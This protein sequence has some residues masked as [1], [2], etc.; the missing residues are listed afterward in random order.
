MNSSWDIKNVTTILLIIL[1]C[2]GAK[3]QSTTKIAILA[4]TDVTLNCSFKKPEHVPLKKITVEWGMMV[5]KETIKHLVYTF[6]NESAKV[7]REGSRVDQTGLLQGNASLRLFN[8]TVADEGL[9]RCRVIITPNTYKVSSQLEVSA[10]PSVSL[11]ETAMV[12]EGEERTLMCDITGFYPENLAVT[13]LIQNGSRVALGSMARGAISRDV[14][15]GMAV[16][17][18]DG[19]YSVSSHI[20]V[21]ASAVGSGGAMYICHIEHRSYPD[22]KYSKSILLTVQDPG[23]NAVTLMVVTS[24]VSGLLVFSVIGGAM[25]FYRYFYTVPPSI[26]DIIKPTIVYAMKPTNL[27]CTIKRVRLREFKVKW[28]KITANRDCNAASNSQSKA[29]LSHKNL[30]DQAN[31]HSESTHH[32]STLSVCLSVREDQAKY[33]CVVLYRGRK[34]TRETTVSVKVT[35]SFFHISSMPQIPEVKRLLVLCCR[36]EKFYPDDLHLEWSRND[37]E[38]VRTVTNYGPFSDHERMYSMWSKIELTIAQE[39]EKVV[40][41]CRLYHSSFAGPGYKDVLYHINTQGTPPSVM[42]IKCEP[43]LPLLDEECTLNLCVKDFCPEQVSVTWFKDGQTVPNSQ[44]FNSPP[45][46]NI[47]GLYSMWSFLKLSHTSEDYGS[48][49]R[50]RVVHSAQKEPEERVFTH[51]IS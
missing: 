37:G 15:T 17:N 39:D 48:E 3:A 25:V 8:M 22:G 18:P 50:C 30:S 16:P 33:L 47:N 31:I 6:Q 4:G 41:T 11:P 40:Y 38:Q 13:W 28:Y 36:V 14:C 42:F 26:S 2:K 34:I 51:Q 44:F 43:L 24:L 32:V 23:F 19:T 46:L 12:M 5:D 27:K 7:H 35:P 29:L 21:Q 1:H 10:R 49:F 45:S 20:T 9:Y